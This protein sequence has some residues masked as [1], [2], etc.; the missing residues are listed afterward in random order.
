MY[1]L[2]MFRLLIP[3]RIMLLACLT[4]LV[5]GGCT[6]KN[7]MKH[8]VVFISLDTTRYDY[9]DTGKGAHAYTPHLKK[10][11]EN[12]IVFDRAFSTCTQTLPSH[13][14]VFTSR[15]PHELG[16][17]GN[18][19]KYDGRH[20][21][22]QQVFT[23]LGYHTIA[24]TSLGTLGSET[25]VNCGFQ[26]FHEGLGESMVFFAP[27]EKI[28]D[29]A[30]AAIRSAGNERFFLFVH[31]S[32]P[33]TPYAPPEITGDFLITLDEKPIAHLDSYRGAI[34]KEK[35]PLTRGKH[36]M[37]FKAD[38]GMEDFSH[39]VIRGLKTSEGSSFT[40]GTLEYSETLYGG[41][42]RMKGPQG[43]IEIL[44]D[45]DGFVQIFQII[46]ILKTQSAVEYYRLEVEYMDRYVGKFLE[47][48]DVSGFKNN[49]I[50]VLFAD[51]GEG[52]GEREGY[53][54]HTKFLNSQFIHVPL[55]VKIP[56]WGSR[57]VEAPVSLAGISPA[58]LEYLGCRD[59]DF[60][61]DKNILKTEEDRTGTENLIYSF[62]FDP[63]AGIHKISIIKWP[64]QGIFNFSDGRLESR[65]YYNLDIS[66]SFYTRDAIDDETMT[67]ASREYA[68]TFI[69][70]IRQMSGIL[71]VPGI[72]SKDLGEKEMEKLRALG[73]IRD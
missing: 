62:A 58:V 29:E 49:T 42:H 43:R 60:D 44:A 61:F 36:L 6:R 45:K 28:T 17:Y 32:D 23:E 31:Y 69:Q 67:E 13:L 26:K 65:E 56:G 54:G 55:I 4:L 52:H 38:H 11:A 20:K 18:D 71:R 5:L 24:V 59:K 27:A 10:F 34:L 57:R 25:G 64:F 15:F 68:E 40:G 37:E 53:F 16:V 1:G 41:A 12:S 73:Y 70:K 2:K 21:T 30:I 8:N 72:R 7:S 9:I 50:I 39:F 46:P 35:I 63:S 22:I 47:K 66:P 51:H 14:S 48:L 33:H 3:K 19:D